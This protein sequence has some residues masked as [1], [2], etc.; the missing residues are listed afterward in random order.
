VAGLTPKQPR[1]VTF[2]YPEQ[3]LGKALLI[4]GDET[5]PLDVLLEKCGTVTGRLVDAD[6]IPRAGIRIWGRPSGGNQAEGRG[7]DVWATTDKEGRFRIEG[8]IPG[9]PYNLIT[10]E[11]PANRSDKL[12]TRRLTVQPGKTKDLGDVPAVR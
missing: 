2:Y 7:R 1:F 8:M 12:L 10:H 6:R 11:D 9:F 3:Q 4:R 5:A